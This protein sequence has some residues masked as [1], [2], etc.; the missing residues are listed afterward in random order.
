MRL[1]PVVIS[2]FR[3]I[4]DG[5]EGG[6]GNSRGATDEVLIGLAVL[7]EIDEIFDLRA[8]LRG[9]GTQLLEQELFSLCAHGLSPI[10]AF[11][12]SAE[13]AF[14]PPVARLRRKP[15]E[16]LAMRGLELKNAYCRPPIPQLSSTS[17]V[18]KPCLQVTLADTA[19]AIRRRRRA[20]AG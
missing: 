17:A 4:P 19:I 20:R 10:A 18:G 12:S 3:I 8:P 16:A 11:R 1:Q 9:E 13:A 2:I 15:R 7:Q 5:R 14:Y 6:L